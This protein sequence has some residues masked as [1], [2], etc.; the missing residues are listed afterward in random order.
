MENDIPNTL[1]EI[2]QGW[3]NI[4]KLDTIPSKYQYNDWKYVGK[5]HI[6]DCLRRSFAYKYEQGKLIYGIFNYLAFF[7]NDFNSH[8]IVTPEKF[9]ITI[10]NIIDSREDD[11]SYNV[12]M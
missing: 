9:Q 8:I 2:F 11:W 4:P 3:K 12:A 7:D 6:K 1:K 10:I 5:I